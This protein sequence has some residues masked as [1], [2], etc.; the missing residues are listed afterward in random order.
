MLKTYI[1]APARTYQTTITG[2]QSVRRQ[3]ICSAHTYVEDVVLA[4]DR[5]FR[6]H[7]YA[8]EKQTLHAHMDEYSE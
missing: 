7:A 5:R 3:C 8:C 4:D 6:T 1:P 2:Q